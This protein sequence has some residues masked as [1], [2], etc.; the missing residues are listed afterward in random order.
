MAAGYDGRGRNIC[1]VSVLGILPD[2]WGIEPGGKVGAS[3]W[4]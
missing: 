1:C 4:V 2:V 3:G